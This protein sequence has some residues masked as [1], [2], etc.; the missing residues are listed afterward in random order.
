MIITIQQLIEHYSNYVDPRGKI[1]RDVKNGKLFPVT[2]GIYET[3]QNADG[4]YLAQFIYGPSYLSFD[5]VLF[6]SGLIPET[7]YN[8]YTCATYNKRKTKAYTN[9]FGTYVYRDIPKA[10]F[11]YGVTV[12]SEGTYSC[13]IA[14]AEKALCDKLYT[15]A[16]ASSMKAFKELLFDHLRIYE[17]NL[18]ELDREFIFKIAPLYK[19]QNLNWLVKYLREN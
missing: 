16:P 18:L 7:V 3:N 6:N 14:N 15:L 19:K 12:L 10:V 2:R 5:T 17:D 9:R 4:L 1:C 8:T 13:Q 11:S